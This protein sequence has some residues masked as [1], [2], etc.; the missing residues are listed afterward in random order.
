MSCVLFSLRNVLQGLFFDVPLVRIWR[1]R[2]VETLQLIKIFIGEC[3]WY[4]MSISD[5]SYKV[6]YCSARWCL[7]IPFFSF[8]VSDDI[9]ILRSKYFHCTHSY[10][11][12]M[13]RCRYEISK[14]QPIK[15]HHSHVYID[16]LQFYYPLNFFSIIIQTLH[17][18]FVLLNKYLKCPYFCAVK[19]TTPRGSV[20]GAD[21]LF[22]S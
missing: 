17:V 22:R 21:V 3:I 4:S 15:N 5:F 19:P 16:N 6:L 14:C 13:H 8:S 9:L 20:C 1:F 12:K 11:Y 7:F 2:C 18:T 10:T